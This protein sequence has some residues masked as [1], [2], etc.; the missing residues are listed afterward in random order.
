ML[1]SLAPTSCAFVHVYEPRAAV[2]VRALHRKIPGVRKV[3]LFARAEK[4]PGFS[5]VASPRDATNETAVRSSCDDNPDDL[6]LVHD[7]TFARNCFGR[8][9]AMVKINVQLIC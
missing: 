3:S 9:R 6:R 1:G 5:F 4:T 2:H 7:S 8:D